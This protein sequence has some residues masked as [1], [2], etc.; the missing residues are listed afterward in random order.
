[1]S[2]K[3]SVLMVTEWGRCPVTTR[4]MSSPRENQCGEME[5]G[6]DRPKQREERRRKREKEKLKEWVRTRKLIIRSRGGLCLTFL[7]AITTSHSHQLLASCHRNHPQRELL[8]GWLRHA[9]D[10]FLKTLKGCSPQIKSGCNWHVQSGFV[11]STPVSFLLTF[12]WF[13][14]YG[15]LIV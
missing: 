14:L 5:K 6:A 7:S 12:A 13:L 9:G 1:M 10:V 11:M 15:L 8:P 3:E 4:L 2:G